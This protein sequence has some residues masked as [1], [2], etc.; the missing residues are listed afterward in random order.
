MI[1]TVVW[2]NETFLHLPVCTQTLTAIFIYGKL[3]HMWSKCESQYGR[4][5]SCEKWY[6]VYIIGKYCILRFMRCE[7]LLQ[8]KL[9]LSLN[10]H[11]QCSVFNFFLFLLFLLYSNCFTLWVWKDSF[12]YFISYRYACMFLYIHTNMCILIKLCLFIRLC[13][14][15]E[16]FLNEWLSQPFLCENLRT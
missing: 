1:D 4:A 16:C 6:T 13:K 2:M 11:M 5:I 3:I 8:Q 15:H 9:T 12:F 14:C 10:S 7:M